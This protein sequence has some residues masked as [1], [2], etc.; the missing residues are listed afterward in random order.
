MERFW[1]KNF[2]KKLQDELFIINNSSDKELNKLESISSSS[3]ICIEQKSRK[4]TTKEKK[5]ISNKSES[6]SSSS[7]INIEQLSRKKSNK[8]N[9]TL[10][11]NKITSSIDS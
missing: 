2:Q 7:S 3:S 9:K 11:N 1:L 8:Q 4:K 5:P 6:I 10:L